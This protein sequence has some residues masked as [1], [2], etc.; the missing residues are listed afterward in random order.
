MKTIFGHFGDHGWD[1][2]HLV[3]IRLRVLALQRLSTATARFGLDIM[4]L[5]DLLD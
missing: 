3:T 2:C 4:A 1:F 5:F